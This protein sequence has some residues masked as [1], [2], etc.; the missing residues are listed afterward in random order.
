MGPITNLF[1]NGRLKLEQGGCANHDGY[2]W[3]FLIISQLVIPNG[4]ATTALCV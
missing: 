2:L 4:A 3:R 1:E